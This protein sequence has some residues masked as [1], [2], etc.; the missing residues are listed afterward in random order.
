MNNV[1]LCKNCYMP[2]DNI[3]F[4]AGYVSES[5]KRDIRKKKKEDKVVDFTSGKKTLSAVYLKTGQVVLL[6]TSPDTVNN[7]MEGKEE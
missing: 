2:I 7:R 1:K 6:N 3:L 4:V 5:I